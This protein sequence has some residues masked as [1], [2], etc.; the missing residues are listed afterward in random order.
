MGVYITEVERIINAA[1]NNQ[2]FLM[3]ALKIRFNSTNK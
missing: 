3:K 2:A 1:K